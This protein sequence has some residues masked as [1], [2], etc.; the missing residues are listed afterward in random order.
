MLM[1]PIFTENL[2]FD[3]QHKGR[4]SATVEQKQEGAYF[5]VGKKWISNSGNW[6]RKGAPLME[7][8]KKTM[9]GEKNGG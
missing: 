1:L 7:T 8:A 2:R 5:Q 3:L 4:K 6:Q 9:E